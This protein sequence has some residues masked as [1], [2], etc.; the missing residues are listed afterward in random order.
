MFTRE[1]AKEV[2]KGEKKLMKLREV[3]FVQVVKYD[4]LSVKTLYQKLIALPY[5]AEYF[6]N[7]YPKG[8]QC[9]RDYMFNIANTLH[10]ETISALTEH[11]LKQ[12]HAVEGIKMKD[13][14]VIIND[15]LAEELK[16][17]PMINHVSTLLI[18]FGVRGHLAFLYRKKVEWSH[19]S[20]RRRRSKSTGEKER[21]TNWLMSSRRER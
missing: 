13:E 11:A 1:F 10:E 15:H 16:A 3:Q 20:N 18:P 2:L 14:S 19:C 17:L 7:K 6:P 4:E 5:M 8:R 12:R 9:D 21:S